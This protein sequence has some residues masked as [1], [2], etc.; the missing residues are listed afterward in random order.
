MSDP[1]PEYDGPGY[2]VCLWPVDPSCLTAEWDA[3]TE[4][5]REQALALASSALQGLTGGR[6]GGCP[7]TI[8][9]CGR[10]ACAPSML[11]WVGSQMF[12]PGIDLNG[13]WV[14][15]AGCGCSGGGC[16]HTLCEVVLPSPVGA[17]YE[18]KVDGVVID[19]QDYRIDNG[20]RLTWQGSGPCPWPAT[21][22]L[23][24]PDTEVGTF[25]VT[26]LNAYAVDRMGAQAV[27]ALALEFAR[28]C[29]GS[30][31]CQLPP[32]VVNVVRGGV[33]YSL[34]PGLWPDGFTGV[35]SVDAYI[36][37][38]NPHNLKQD[39]LVWAPGGV[40]GQPEMRVT[41]WRAPVGP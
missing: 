37:L 26:F 33:T 17:V 11:P 31:N 23:S 8:R 34:K 4:P 13:A 2:G 20:N 27:A 29:T 12:R 18:V 16:G 7:I 35:D 10:G 19:D 36:T 5:Q 39:S 40:P 25:S 24:L 3:L 6:V 21:Q 28:A 32:S 30:Q 41:T 14:N 22:D 15:N 9:P 38:W 1:I